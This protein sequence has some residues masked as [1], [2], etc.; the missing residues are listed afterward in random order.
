MTGGTSFW[1]RFRGKSPKPESS[2]NPF[3]SPAK[4]MQAVVEEAQ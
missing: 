1:K 2:G 4:R 3:N